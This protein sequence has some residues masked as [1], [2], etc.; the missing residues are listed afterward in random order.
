M[1][2]KQLHN[3]ELKFYVFQDDEDGEHSS[4]K[5]IVGFNVVPGLFA[6]NIKNNDNTGLSFVSATGKIITLPKDVKDVTFTD[7]GALFGFTINENSKEERY[8]GAVRK[9]GT[10]EENFAGYLKSFNNQTTAKWQDRVYKDEISIKLPKQTTV[11]FGK[12][13]SN[14]CGINLYSKKYPNETKDSWNSGGNEDPINHTDFTI[15]L[16]PINS[17]IIESNEA[18]NS[19]EG[20]HMFIDK[21]K[22]ISDASTKEVII[23]I[24]NL[25][26][27][28]PSDSLFLKEIEQKGIEQLYGWQQ[29]EY[30]EGNWNRS[31]E[32][33]EKFNDSH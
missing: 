7:K 22:D 20:G 32:A 11:Y 13:S 5:F 28:S 21:Y 10:S 14:P 12:L 6:N 4:Y 25:I 29:T 26:C 3:P 24:A 31:K 23:D 2:W 1:D 9:A 17:E 15:N 30:F 19:C 16:N 33:F 18:C 27:N 8:I